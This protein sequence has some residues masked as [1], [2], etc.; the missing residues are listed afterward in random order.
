MKIPILSGIF[1]DND[2]SVRTAYPLNYIPVAKQSGVNDSYLRPADGITAF[3]DGPGADRG[4]INW[5]RGCY[6]VMGDQL[7]FVQSSG[8]V[9]NIGS[10]EGADALVSM[11]YSFDLLAIWSN[12]KLWYYDGSTI[13]Q[14]TDPNLGSVID[15]IW[16]DGYFL[17]TD[18]EFIFN[19]TLADPTVVNALSYASSEIDPDPIVALL[20]LRNE[21]Y[22]LNRYTIEI[23]NNVGGSGFPFQ[24]KE[25]AQIQKGCVGTHACCVYLESIAFVGSGRN[26]Q[27]SVYLGRNSVANK[28]STREIDDIL[29]GYTE[30]ELKLIKVEARNDR[31]SQLL[32]IH[33]PNE[34]LVYDGVASQMLGAPVWCRLSSS[35][36]GT[37]QYLGYNMVYVYDKWIVG[38]PTGSRVGVLDNSISSHWDTK[39]RWEI[40][41]QMIYNE[42]RG[43]IFHELELV[44]LPGRIALGDDPRLSTSYSVDGIVWSQDD[45]INAGKIG[46]RTKRIQWRRQGNMSNFRIQRFRGDSDAHLSFLRLEAK[47]EPLYV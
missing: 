19:T 18:G 5:N 33:L 41:T 17:S 3:G 4:A 37:G 42:S 12:N 30:N 35:V 16:I 24:R 46:E 23:F 7:V 2:P 28:V 38:D 47:L 26:E 36:D 10:V 43:A 21:A 44:T 15:G 14:V 9:T 40:S 13:T 22:A 8:I 32:Y 45:Y 27:P 1:T 25:G 31:S 34:T 20:K 29:S 6:R 11:D 39:V